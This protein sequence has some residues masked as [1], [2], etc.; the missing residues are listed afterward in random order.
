MTKPLPLRGGKK[1]LSGEELSIYEK[2]ADANSSNQAK[3]KK[4]S[5]K[6]AGLINDTIWKYNPNSD[7]NKQN[8]KYVGQKEEYQD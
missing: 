1:I 8:D 3:P 4:Q 6:F 7:Y 2:L 5:E